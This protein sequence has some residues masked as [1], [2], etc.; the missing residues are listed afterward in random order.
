MKFFT[1][2]V[3]GFLTIKR[4]SAPGMLALL[5]GMLLAGATGKLAA[6]AVGIGTTSPAAMLHIVNDTSFREAFTINQ[7]LMGYA[8]A[9]S[10][11]QR[12]WYGHGL[13]VSMPNPVSTGRGLEVSNSGGGLAMYGYAERNTGVHGVTGT[14]TAAGVYGENMYGEAVVGRNRGGNGVGAVVGRNDSSGSGVR[15]F[16]TKTGIG[17]LGQSGISGGTGVAGVFQNLNAANFSNVLEVSGNGSGNTIY[18]STLSTANAAIRA[19]CSGTNGNGIISTASTGGNPFAIWGI[20]NNPTGFAGYFTGNVHVLGT[21]SK[22]MGSFKIDH[23]VDPANKYLIHSFVESPDMMNIYNG[24][25]VTD[26]KGVAVV[27]LPGYFE[28]ENM[29][30]KYQLTILDETRFA[31]AR[32]AKKISN[33]QFVIV[34][35]KPN[36]EVSWAVTGVRNDA[37][38]KAHRIVPEVEKLGE[39]RGRYLTPLEHG[40]TAEM[41]VNFKKEMMSR[42]AGNTADITP[43]DVPLASDGD[44][45][46]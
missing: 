23:P 22:S 33:N 16:C 4:S 24:N 14:I 40:K 11:N 8:N 30:F 15:G 35:D 42:V 6:Q 29:D 10:I 26:A 2:L 41:G 36:I 21:L 5:L 25:V 46:K 39:E 44:G 1:L 9:V 27:K 3:P 45:K 37:Y 13:I 38:A 17:V 7:N 12:S 18:A 20:S 19:F 31:Q 28:A 43:A 32:V 34:T